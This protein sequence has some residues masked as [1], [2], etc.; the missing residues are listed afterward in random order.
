MERIVLLRI[1]KRKLKWIVNIDVRVERKCWVVFKYK[2]FIILYFIIDYIN[3]K[4]KRGNLY[5][6]YGCFILG[7]C[8][9]LGFVD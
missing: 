4:R 9:I 3:R 5:Y 8:V 7:S 1:I 2:N 6:E